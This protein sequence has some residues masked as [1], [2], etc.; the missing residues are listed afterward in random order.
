MRFRNVSAVAAL[1]VLL[2]VSASAQH[3]VFRS[4]AS[5]A[6]VVGSPTKLTVSDFDHDGFQDVILTNNE[7]PGEEIGSCFWFGL[8]DPTPLDCR[9]RGQPGV[10]FPSALLVRDFDGDELPDLLIASSDENTVAFVK[11]TGDMNFFDLPSIAQPVGVNP[12]G[13]AAGDIDG[14]DFVDVAVAAEGSTEGAP[15]MVSVLR[16]HGDGSFTVC[17]MLDAQAGT[18]AVAFGDFNDDQKDD[19]L[20]LNSRAE[21]VSEWFG[22]GD[23][24]FTARPTIPTGAAPQG[25]A[26]GDLDGD[27]EMDFVTADSNT[28]T[29]SVFLGRGD[30]TFRPRR[31][32]ATG[33]APNGVWI[34]DLNGDDLP[35][36][37]ATNNRSQD[38]S[39]LLGEGSGG[40]L[41]ARSWVTGAE[42]EDVAF[43]DMDGDGRQDVIAL[44]RGAP[45][46]SVLK[47]LGAGSFLGV[48]DIGAGNGPSTIAVGDVDNDALPDL[49]AGNDA[50]DV[51]VFDS[52]GDGSFRAPR[53]TNLGGRLVAVTA[54][55]FDGDGVIDVAGADNEN[56]VVAVAHGLGDG[57]FGQVRTYPTAESPAGI[58]TGDF[59][60]D[61]RPDLALT[62]VGPPGRVSVFLQ[63]ANGTFATAKNTTVEETPLGIATGD[64]DA[65]GR[66]DM[67][68]ANQASQTVSVLRST[69]GGNFTLK[70]T[71]PASDNNQ[72]PLAAAVT[73]YNRDGKPDFIVTNTSG[74]ISIFTGDGDATFTGVPFDDLGSP[75]AEYP[76]SVVARDFTGD[77]LVDM[78]VLNQTSNSVRV[79][80]G[81]ND[82]RFKNVSAKDVTVSRMPVSIAAADFDG[83][84][85]YDAATANSDP[86]ANN[87]SILLNCARDADCYYDDD[88]IFANGAQPL[89]GMAALRGDGNDDGLVSAGDLVA[90]SA[91]VV[92][93]DGKAVEDID[94]KGFQASAGV[95]ANG[96]GRVDAQDRLAVA[97]RIFSGA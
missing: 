92:D 33:T 36:L 22:D 37:V 58:A 42:P 54:A 25:L 49:I 7:A 26:A 2:P 63:Q 67:V 51:L 35:D 71:V 82:G 20:A 61:G 69:G 66:D 29:V 57:S 46:A 93:G 96:D 9:R 18:T 11:G 15:G 44:I 95:D 59:D 83:D 4:A 19:L 56:S 84:G 48:E 74:K 14:N 88:G 45:G 3:G 89:P 80:I 94:M 85:R 13:L 78:A 68:V 79:F 86:S 70:Q 81:R 34:M 8:S 40:F 38:L 64:F 31:S 60:G 73:D 87:V 17:A 53:V 43:A 32:F 41:P 76:S 62:A 91:E 28:D 50:G 30:G 52:V 12:R 24:G 23:C 77:G 65:D 1:A 75:A 10:R 97:A 55:D 16:G 47:N 5:D 39:V 6:V 27:G 90:V 21:R 72:G